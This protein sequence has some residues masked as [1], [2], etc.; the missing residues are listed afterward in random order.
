MNSI[1]GIIIIFYNIK[2]TIN[3]IK[4]YRLRHRTIKEQCRQIA[5][6]IHMGQHAGKAGRLCAN[7]SPFLRACFRTGAPRPNPSDRIRPNKLTHRATCPRNTG[8]QETF[9]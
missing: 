9:I 7:S 4:Y 1:K 6:T 5:W 2:T 3:I 8:P